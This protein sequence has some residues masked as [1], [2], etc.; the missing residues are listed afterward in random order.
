MN[1][2]RLES[3]YSKALFLYPADFRVHY[4]SAMRQSLRDALTD[5]GQPRRNF[6]FLLVRDLTTSLLKEHF[7]MLRE[8]YL[9][10]ALIFN[11][12]VLSGI[13]TV[14]ALALS[15][16]PQQIL[17]LGA[18][19][20]QVEMAE[21]LAQSLKS[22]MPVDD[23]AMIA[24]DP[25]MHKKMSFILTAA[26]AHPQT[27]EIKG[28]LISP[29]QPPDGKLPMPANTLTV[30]TQAKGIKREEVRTTI[31]PRDDAHAKGSQKT[32]ITTVDSLPA[33]T[34]QDLDGNVAINDTIDIAQSLSPFLIT[35]DAEGNPVASR[36]KLNGKIPSPPKGVFNDVR[37]IGEERF[38]WQ[39]AGGARYATVVL[40]IPASGNV[41]EG[42]VLAGRSMREVESRI[43]H[44]SQLA[45]LTWLGMMGLIL[46]GTVAFG[47][48]TRP[49]VEAAVI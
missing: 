32:E 1:S 6:V 21:N 11:A 10:P 28:N 24:G 4:G 39:P 7:T 25:L 33:G 9:R 8:T 19:D 29:P 35:Y 44:T 26:M 34:I 46:V 16:I 47:W 23:A 41:K 45:L 42:F 30:D 40:H 27:K 49:R 22:G 12:L 36:A 31:L 5:A 3:L 2:T 14:L 17:R 37:S 20:P 13:A 38:T 43:D 48:W 18:N 15:V